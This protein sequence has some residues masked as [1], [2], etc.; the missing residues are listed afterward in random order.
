VAGT[1]HHALLFSVEMGFHELFLPEL[2]LN[3]DPQISTSEV[4]WDDTQ[5]LVEIRSF[6]LCS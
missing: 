5:L 3:H 6:K 1:C 2:A 4:A